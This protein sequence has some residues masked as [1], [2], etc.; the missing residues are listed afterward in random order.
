MATVAVR[1][2]RLSNVVKCEFGKERNYERSVETLVVPADCQIGTVFNAADGTI[3]VAADTVD[4]SGGV[5]ILV[6]EA[7]YTDGAGT[8]DY[9]VLRGGVGASGAAEVV[10]AGLKY[11]D[12]LSAP[13]VAAVVAQLNA[14][15]IRAV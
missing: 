12:A 4:L 15:G 9:A 5:W 10:I 7:A 2:Q 1:P 13:Q 3:L 8:A 6:D 11:G 14:Q